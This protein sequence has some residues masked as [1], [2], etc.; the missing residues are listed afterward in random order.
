MFNSRFA[1]L[2]TKLSLAAMFALT[3][4]PSNAQ[5]PKAA[6]IVP[7]N[8]VAIYDRHG[9]FIGNA[10][11]LSSTAATI[12]FKL[13]DATDPSDLIV[14]QYTW[15]FGGADWFGPSWVAA[16][17]G[18]SHDE[19]FF[20]GENCTGRSFAAAETS[21]T[22]RFVAVSSDSMLWASVPRAIVAKQS[23]ESHLSS[24]TSACLG[25][26]RDLDSAVEVSTLGSLNLLFPPPLSVALKASDLPPPVPP[27]RRAA[28]H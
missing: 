20:E 8:A 25:Q 24:L 28:H 12:A 22:P 4:L 26:H 23:S 19:I 14:V 9:T 5:T 10:I 21:A 15:I 3:I 6:A 11:A 13:I 7:V 16:N 2:C 17:S 27:R 1:I 18:E